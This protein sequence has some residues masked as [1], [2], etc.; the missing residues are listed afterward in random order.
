VGVSFAESKQNIVGNQPESKMTPDLYV[1]HVEVMF[2]NLFKT[3]GDHDVTLDRD[4]L[5]PEYC[6]SVGEIAIFQPTAL[7]QIRHFY[8]NYMQSV[9]FL[10]HPTLDFQSN[11]KDI[12]K[13]DPQ[14]TEEHHMMHHLGHNLQQTHHALAIF[15]EHLNASHSPDKIQAQ[16][17]LMQF[18]KQ[19]SEFT[20]K[21]SEDNNLPALQAANLNAFDFDAEKAKR[22]RL[23]TK[24][25]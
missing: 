5:L 17:K 4:N 23:L 25:L 8:A 7:R 19:L 14:H 21:F 9:E 11:T 24:T 3:M 12:V 2:S 20:E 16:E 1:Q 13:D 15:Q 6:A 22:S 18:Q 10:I